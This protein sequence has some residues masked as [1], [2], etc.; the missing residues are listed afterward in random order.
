[1][2]ISE[3][4][5]MSQPGV[6]E[7]LLL[8]PIIAAAAESD[9][10]EE[11]E[12]QRDDMAAMAWAIEA[13]IEGQS[14]RALRRQEAYQRTHQQPVPGAAGALAYRLVTEV[15][16]YWIPLVPVTTPTANNPAAIRLQRAAL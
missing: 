11:V 10:V 4:D 14:G 16:D 6:G 3:T 13:V 8:P 12:F 5:G 7:S 15:P 9:P 1:Y 2:R